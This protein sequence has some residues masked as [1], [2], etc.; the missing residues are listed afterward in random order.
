MRIA[1]GS[2]SRT[3]SDVVGEVVLVGNMPATVIGVAQEKQSMF[4]SSKSAARVAAL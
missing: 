2:Y 3:K 1:K 4:G